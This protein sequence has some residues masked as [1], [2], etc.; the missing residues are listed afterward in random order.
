MCTNP[1]S[2]THVS[3]SQLFLTHSCS[4]NALWISQQLKNTTGVVVGV[5]QVGLHLVLHGGHV[6]AGDDGYMNQAV[7]PTGKM[8]C[9]YCHLHVTPLNEVRSV[10]YGLNM[11]F[12]VERFI[13]R[14]LF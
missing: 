10:C 5:A 1:E 2:Q 6:C 8:L 12:R 7:E 3:R 13:L 9:C 11:D 14:Y 4:L